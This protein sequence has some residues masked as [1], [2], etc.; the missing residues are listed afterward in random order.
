MDFLTIFLLLFYALFKALDTTFYL[1][2]LKLVDNLV[3]QNF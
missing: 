3:L 1:K 2:K